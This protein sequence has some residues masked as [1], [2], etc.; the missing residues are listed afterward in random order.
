MMHVEE[1]RVG[2]AWGAATASISREHG[3]TQ[4]WWDA[5]LGTRARRIHI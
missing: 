1:R 4:R 2:A 5:L 3:A